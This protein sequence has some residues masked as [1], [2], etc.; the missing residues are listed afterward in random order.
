MIIEVTKS[1][2]KI[3]DTKMLQM[4]SLFQSKPVEQPVVEER[5]GVTGFGSQD[6][7]FSVGKPNPW[8]KVGTVLE[9]APSVQEA[10]KLSGLDWKVEL[11]DIITTEG[12]PVKQKAAVRTDI[13][14][15]LGIVSDKYKI[16]QNEDA[17][18]WFEP[19]VDNGLATLE[20]A[21]SLFNGKKV[22]IQAKIAGDD[23]VI[24]ERNN[25]IVKKYI[26]LSN[27]HDGGTAVRVGFTP[28]RVIC[29]NTL[30][31]AH[32]N[33]Y[34]NLIRVYHMGNMEEILLQVRETMDLI[35]QQFIATEELYKEL[36][37]KQVNSKDL[38]KYVYQVFSKESLEKSF[39]DETVVPE[40]EIENFRK[41]L[42]DR[43][44][45]VFALE[46][47][48]TAWTAY[49]AVNHYLNH[50]KGRNE[51][52]RINSLCFNGT[53]MKDDARALILAKNL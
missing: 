2:Q 4:F 29:N 34:S 38:K 24:D 45:E 39:Q 33:R 9:N 51:E 46:Y 28:I 31:T 21:G 17:F 6:T 22:F 12:I 8:H 18:N 23:M 25:D 13:K 47:A 19:F 37:K 14:K 27:S 49:N 7:S 32:G 10:I 3:G 1:V 36:A 11:Q 43:V 44:E 26:L 41:R 5:I 30:T 15:A 52:N 48:Q 40:H 50:D 16:L 35:N 20:T 53:S 42:M